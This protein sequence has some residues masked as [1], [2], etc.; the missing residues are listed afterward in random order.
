M[1]DCVDILVEVAMEEGGITERADEPWMPDVEMREYLGV[2]SDIVC[3]AP[4]RYPLANLCA[5]LRNALYCGVHYV[6]QTSAIP[7]KRQKK[8]TK[9]RKRQGGYGIQK[10]VAT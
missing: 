2:L 1:C 6:G 8:K 7:K 3:H 9:K 4:V 5:A 10:V